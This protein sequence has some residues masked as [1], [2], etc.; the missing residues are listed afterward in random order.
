M[1]RFILQCAML[2]GVMGCAVRR[3]SVELTPLDLALERVDTAWEARTDKGLERARWALLD[4]EKATEG[5]SPAV[6]WRWVRWYIGAGLAQG[7][8]TRSIRYLSRARFEGLQCLDQF[9]GFEARRIVGR[10]EEAVATLPTSAS[11][12]VEWTLRAWTRWSLEVGRPAS[13]LDIDAVTALEVYPVDDAT[14][15]DWV[16]MAFDLLHGRDAYSD[17]AILAEVRN[18]SQAHG[19]WVPWSDAV[20]LRVDGAPDMA[21]EGEAE[22]PEERGTLTRRSHRATR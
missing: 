7:D 18:A 20:L 16:R 10:G 11:P 13:A 14:R 12:C 2:C 21:P 22:T 6:A 17:R 1:V 19:P 8:R 15:D 9:A 4:A 5:R 3:N